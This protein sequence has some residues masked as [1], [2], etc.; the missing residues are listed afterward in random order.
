MLLFENS[1]LFL[2]LEDD[3]TRLGLDLV[4]LVVDFGQFLS[5]LFLVLDNLKHLVLLLGY[6]QQAIPLFLNLPKLSL[7]F[8]DQ[9]LPI[10]HNQV[11]KHW[12]ELSFGHKYLILEFHNLQLLFFYL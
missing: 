2:C 11:I 9:V 10:G 7:Q 6:I 8:Y 4:V 1:L 12:V 5:V 3:L